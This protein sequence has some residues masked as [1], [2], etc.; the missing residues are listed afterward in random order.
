MWKEGLSRSAN[1][2]NLFIIADQAMCGVLVITTGGT[3]FQSASNIG[4][5]Q[6]SGPSQLLETC[7]QHLPGVDLHILDLQVRS[8]A[9]LVWTTIFAVRDAVVQRLAHFQGF[10]LITGTDTMDECAFSLAL[11]LDRL[12]ARENKAL[13]ITGAMKPADQLGFDG[14]ANVVQAVKARSCRLSR[15]QR[16]RAQLYQGNAARRRPQLSRWPSWLHHYPNRTQVE[17]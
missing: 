10:L 9:E 3:I 17:F 15:L 14:A 8:G 4:T 7:K 12:L 16:C 11:L 5:M 2:S 1:P 13:A 6:L